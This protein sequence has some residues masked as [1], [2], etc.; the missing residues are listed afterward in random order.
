MSAAISMAA[1]CGEDT[2]PLTNGPPTTAPT[3]S[4]VTTA[5]TSNSTTEQ[6]N[7]S[8]EPTTVGTSAAEP[9]STTSDPSG[10]V[11]L[12][13]KT[14]VS[15]LTEGESV[16]FT[17][18]M[19]DP[20][21]ADDIVGG[22]LSNDDE[23][24]D[25]GPLTAAGQEGTY[26]LTLSWAQIHQALPIQFEDGSMA[27]VFRAVFFDQA[28]HKASDT[29][30]LTLSCPGGSACAGVCT[31][32]A[33]DGLN[34]GTCGR[35]CRGGEDFCE[36][37]ACLQSY[38]S[39]VAYDQGLDTCAAICQAEGE[40]CMQNACLGDATLRGFSTAEH[41]EEFFGNS[42]LFLGCDEPIQWGLNIYHARCCC[43]DSG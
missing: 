22:S 24:L 18:I 6:T 9:T 29:I 39:C 13:F 23:S 34:C 5:P 10:P 30:E 35:T 15:Q 4:P 33:V 2:D 38:S 43:S 1:A 11:F 8:G 26:S 7:S 14:N 36:N 16:T 42:Y 20:D 32:L 37:G 25:F 21:G 41:C 31:D 40:T 28:G 17:A 27:L 3:G 12:S 19:T